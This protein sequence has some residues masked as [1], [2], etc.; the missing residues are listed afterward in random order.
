MLHSQDACSHGV[1]TKETKDGCWP[2]ASD[3]SISKTSAASRLCTRRNPSG[4]V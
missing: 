1:V 3:H 2:A 4:N